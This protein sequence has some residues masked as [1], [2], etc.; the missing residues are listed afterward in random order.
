M[1]KSKAS[2][3]YPDRHNI[4]PT[5]GIHQEATNCK[6]H[7]SVRYVHSMSQHQD[8]QIARLVN[9][10]TVRMQSWCWKFAEQIIL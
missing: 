7:H 1:E 2:E 8:F 4:Q 5:Q 3:N 10:N 6:T 9:A